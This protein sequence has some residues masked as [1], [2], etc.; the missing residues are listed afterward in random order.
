[1]SFRLMDSAWD[2]VLDEALAADGNSVRV[3]C[4]FIKEKS[5][6]RLLAHGR[7]KQFEV[8][9]R[10]NL[11]CFRDGVSDVAALRILL[12]AG[13]K[14]RGVR[15][16][17]AKVYLI[18]HGHA[19]VT[20]AN[21]TEH[22]LTRNH[23]FGFHAQD[24]LIAK[25]CHDY[26][27][28]LWGAAGPD[29]TLA[30]LDRWDAK[31]TAAWASGAGTKTT[32]SLGDEGTDLGLADEPRS[33]TIPIDLPEQGFVKFFGTSTNRFE[34]SHPIF[35]EVDRSGCYFACNY[36]ANKRPRSVRDG[37]VMFM[38]RLA[39]NPTDIVVF[40]R[41]IGM[42]YEEG[43]DDASAADIAKRPW[44]IDWPRYIRVHNAEFIDGSLSNGIL[45]SDLMA[46]LGP[47]SFAP[48]ARNAESGQGNTEPRRAF[49]QQAAVELTPA[50]ISWLTDRMDR[51]LSEKG[52]ISA[53]RLA[54]LDW[55][56]I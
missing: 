5:A 21:L 33:S 29:L 47:Q 10:Y 42:H 8:I 52:R 54:T 14:I 44:K 30:S 32:P 49:N 50:G 12:K 15:N 9:T 13:A 22:G 51:A 53:A 35:D 37:A 7:P 2:K 56:K 41:A 40:G 34:H 23:E 3:I 19:V 27:A 1:M 25:S 16:L 43:R 4:P 18:G 6:K 45:L 26:F 17:H 11:D 24:Q 28:K 39:K 20:S 31:V 38:A 46:A 48:T 55:P 36:P